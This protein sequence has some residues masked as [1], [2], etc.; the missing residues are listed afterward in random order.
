VVIGVVCFIITV[1]GSRLGPILG[2][3]VGRRAELLGGLILI[4]IGARILFE[5]LRG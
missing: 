1:I 5:H 2:R 3:V 4:A